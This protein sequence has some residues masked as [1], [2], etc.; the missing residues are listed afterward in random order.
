VTFANDCERGKASPQCISVDVYKCGIFDA[1]HLFGRV[2]IPAGL[3]SGSAR[4]DAV[5]G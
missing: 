3:A 5:R 1:V 4:R 2:Q